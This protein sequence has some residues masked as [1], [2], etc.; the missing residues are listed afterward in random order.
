MDT[1]YKFSVQL[2]NSYIIT[3]IR[4]TLPCSWNLF[5]R[6]S[7]VCTKRLKVR[8]CLKWA[9]SRRRAWK[10]GGSWKSSLCSS[11]HR[12][13]TGAKALRG[14]WEKLISWSQCFSPWF[15]K[16]KP[17]CHRMRQTHV[18]PNDDTQLGMCDHTHLRGQT[19]LSTLTAVSSLQEKKNRQT[20]TINQLRIL[21][22]HTETK[23]D[24][25]D[26]VQIPTSLTLQRHEWPLLQR[27]VSGL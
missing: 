1:W 26:A 18:P 7:A 27:W 4:S 21:S 22:S 19:V 12:R 3:M 14:M 5:R 24:T 25:N 10:W 15:K 20:P 13:I 11:S 9:H 6:A 2:S 8:R 16:K 17:A 23:W